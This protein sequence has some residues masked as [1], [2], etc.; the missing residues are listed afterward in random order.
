MK[1]IQKQIMTDY[2]KGKIVEKGRHDD[3]VKNKGQYYNLIKNQLEL[4]G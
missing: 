1:E 4:E 3:L 2:E